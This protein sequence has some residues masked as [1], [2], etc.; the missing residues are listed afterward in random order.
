[1]SLIDMNCYQICDLQISILFTNFSRIQIFRKWNDIWYQRLFVL[2]Q[3]T[4]LKGL[5]NVPQKKKLSTLLCY[6]SIV[7][8]LPV[9]IILIKIGQ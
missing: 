9:K 5:I 7:S 8:D 3:E 6:L 1:M 4:I 2:M